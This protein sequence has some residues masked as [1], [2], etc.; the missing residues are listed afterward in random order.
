MN[1]ETVFFYNNLVFFETRKIFSMAEER[2][3]IDSQDYLIFLFVGLLLELYDF[4]NLI[5]EFNKI[6][7]VDYLF[8]KLI[9]D[10]FI[11]IVKRL[12][13]YKLSYTIF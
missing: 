7:I 5:N 12:F 11:K 8:N 3:I 2:M 6:N 9:I 13:W 10:I 4:L 1:Y